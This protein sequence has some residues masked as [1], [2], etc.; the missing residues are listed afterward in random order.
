MWFMYPG[1]VSLLPCSIKGNEGDFRLWLDENWVLAPGTQVSFTPEGYLTITWDIP[2]REWGEF[3][4]ED[5]DP[6][7]DYDPYPIPEIP[8]LPKTVD[9]DSNEWGF[10]AAG[11]PKSEMENLLPAIGATWLTESARVTWEGEDEDDLGLPMGVVGIAYLHSSGNIGYVDPDISPDA[12]IREPS[13]TEP[14][15]PSPA[16][17][18]PRPRQEWYTTLIPVGESPNGLAVC[19]DARTV[20]VANYEGHIENHYGNTVSVI[21]MSTNTVIA[22]IAVDPY[23]LCVTV[24]DRAHK[25]YIGH[26]SGPV[27]MIDCT[28]NVVAATIP[29]CGGAGRVALNRLDRSLYVSGN[30]RVSVIDTETLAVV[31][32]V[33]VGRGSWG[34]AVD[35][36]AHTAYVANFKD[37]SVSVFDTTTNT[38]ITTIPVGRYPKNVAVD[39]YLHRLYVANSAEDS[40]SVIDTATNTVTA[41]LPVGRSP[42]AV[43]VDGEAHRAYVIN[44]R[45]GTVST[46]DTTTNRITTT[47]YVGDYPNPTKAVGASPSMDQPLDLAVDLTTQKV[48]VTNQG[49]DTV[50]VIETAPNPQA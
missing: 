41:T 12:Y 20:Y 48:Y 11:N 5:D 50:A 22:T 49:N 4:Y 42:E 34:L 19:E 33:P 3:Q 35:E 14:A 40:V 37:H 21:D 17:R 43:S 27:S 31:A 18:H 16:K 39:K 6:F 45:D 9:R 32:T 44:R 1:T 25:A 30:S 7:S 8:A 38:V 26:S 36:Q 2:G 47:T 28:T 29:L 10:L 13:Q 15:P 23:P 46:I 24:D